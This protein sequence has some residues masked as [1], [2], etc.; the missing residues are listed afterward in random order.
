M[1]DALLYISLMRPLLLYENLYL[2]FSVYT[3]TEYRKSLFQILF[4]SSILSSLCE[5]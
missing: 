5:F 3:H 4:I 1:L 2:L